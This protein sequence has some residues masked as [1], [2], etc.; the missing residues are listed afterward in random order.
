MSSAAVPKNASASL[1]FYWLPA[2][3]LADQYYLYMHF[4]ELEKLQANQSRLFNI[5]CNMKPYFGPF[6]PVYL[7]TKTTYSPVALWTG[8]Q[9]NFSIFKV[10]NSS[11]L[12]P[13]INALEIY[14]VKEFP[15][16][17]TNRSDGM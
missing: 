9:Y 5:T 3:K 4:V 17:E 2:D 11:T 10:E 13:L 6:S 12:P 8:G 16:L 14:R 1:D 15:Q 7:Y